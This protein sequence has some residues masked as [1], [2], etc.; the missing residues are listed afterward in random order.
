MIWNKNLLY[1]INDV[2]YHITKLY[3]VN[4]EK[5]Y[6]IKLNHFFYKRRPIATRANLKVNKRILTWRPFWNKVYGAFTGSFD[7]P[8]SRQILDH[9]SWSRSPKGAQ[10]KICLE[11]WVWRQKLLFDFLQLL[12]PRGSD[13]IRPVF[14]ARSGRWTPAILER[15]L[16]GNLKKELKGLQVLLNLRQGLPFSNS[17]SSRRGR[18]VGLMVSTLV[19]GSSTGPG[20]SPGGGHCVVFLGK[21]LNSHGVFIQPGVEIGSGELN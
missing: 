1:Q 3:L 5:N 7:A 19:S 4:N 16:Q 6:K 9:W 21:T 15:C 13:F 2:W 10:A 18:L 14:A 12:T 11:V 20:S 8:W 17:F